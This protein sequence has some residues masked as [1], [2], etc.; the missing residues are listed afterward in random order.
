MSLE[1]MI[2]A[3]LADDNIVHF[4]IGTSGDEI[5]VLIREE[6]QPVASHYRFVS[7]DDAIEVVTDSGWLNI[8]NDLEDL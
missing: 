6:H 3:A 2:R 8:D 5:T 7:L 1:E 4:S